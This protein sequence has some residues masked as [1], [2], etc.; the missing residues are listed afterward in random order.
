MADL[1]KEGERLAI[2]A[3]RSS[4]PPNITSEDFVGKESRGNA[5]GT[6]FKVERAPD[7]GLSSPT[8]N[9]TSSAL[10]QMQQGAYDKANRSNYEVTDLKRKA[11]MSRPLGRANRR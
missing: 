11:M 10:S 7:D 6:P 8:G 3:K 9:L 1:A 2:L 5:G 4:M